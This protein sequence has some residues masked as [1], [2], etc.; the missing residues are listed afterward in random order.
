MDHK[1]TQRRTILTIVTNAVVCGV[2][3][4]AIGSFWSFWAWLGGSLAFG[5][6]AGYLYERFFARFEGHKILFRSRLVFLVLGEVLL[7]IYLVMPA[8]EAYVNLH[9]GRSRVIG[10]PARLGMEYEDVSL[11][12]QDGVVLRAWYIPSH[13]RA[14]LVLLHGFG[15]NRSQLLPY[16]Q[17][18]AE[19]GYGVLLLDMRGQGES[20]PAHFCG[21][22]NGELDLQPAV[23]YLQGRPEVDPQRIGGLGL[24]AGGYEL[25]HAAA[26]IADIR[27]VMVDG[28]EAG[29][30]E[31]YFGP[32]PPEY[33][34]NWFM[35]PVPWL[36]DRFVELGSGVRAAPA[37]KDEVARI[38]PRPV[39]FLSSGK[40]IEQFQT[41]KFYA[42]AGASAQLW[43]LPE[44]GH[45]AGFTLYQQEYTSRMVAFFDHSLLGK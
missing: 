23:S 11:R 30:T 17:A 27:A 7:T 2:I 33:R 32:L 38:A 16:A 5:A 42:R 45:C 28:I 34:P 3:G 26:R 15:G 31:D 20:G 41:R 43:E 44:A 6:A 21:G 22:W 1:I 19:Q 40:G 39:F 25:V 8:V 9:P 12:T 35:T 13:N 10:T 37:I 14:A 4:G 36:T 18:L 24:S 29:R